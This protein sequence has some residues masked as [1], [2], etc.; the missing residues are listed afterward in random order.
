VLLQQRRQEAIV[1][2]DLD[3]LL[4][5]LYVYVD[6]SLPSRS[7]PGRPPRT[8]DSELICLAVAQILLDC[9]SDRQF[10]AVAGRR[11]QHLFP[12]RPKHS[13]YHQRVRRLAP[14]I[15]RALSMLACDTPH[16]DDQLR[17][18]DSTPVPCAQSRTTVRRSEFAGIAGYGYCAAH[19]RWF[20]GFRLYLVC[21]TDGIPVGYELA[22]ANASER[23][24]A[25]ELLERCTTPGQII[26]G[27]KGF[28][29][30]AFE[31]LVLDLDCEFRR[32][33]RKREPERFGHLGGIRQWI[34]AIIWTCKGQLSLERH[35]ARTVETLCARISQRLLA[36][37]ACVWHN[38]RIGHQP[39]RSIACYD[40]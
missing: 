30:T 12:L 3:A 17:L 35:R 26:V 9:H 19:S 4:T 27:D 16:S 28:A 37:A 33:D 24:V 32:P 29:G 25:A 2:P 8:T 21:T 5:A 31:Q 34:E 14:Q 38:H 6:D 11:L 10:L 13:G 22:P 40:H 39:P 15:A 7:G 20:W 18:L 23:D 1:P 36:L